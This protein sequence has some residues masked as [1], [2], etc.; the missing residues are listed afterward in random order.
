MHEFDLVKC[1]IRHT[2]S[3]EVTTVGCAVVYT[4]CTAI[5]L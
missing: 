3:Q 2:F 5:L 1:Y 4:L